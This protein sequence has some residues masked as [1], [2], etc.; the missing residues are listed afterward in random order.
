[1]Q[2]FL[3]NWAGRPPT[4]LQKLA[5][6][7]KLPFS[8]GNRFLT[9]PAFLD[10]E[11][12]GLVEADVGALLDL[13]FTLPRR[14]FDGDLA[15]MA[16]AVGL[17]PV[18]A[19]AIVRTATEYPVRLAR[20]DLFQD[21]GAFKLLEFK[22]SSA[23]GGWDAPLLT[24]WL[25]RD[26][27]LASF[28]GDE[29][30]TF[31]DTLA[32]FASVIRGECVGLDC[33]TRPVVALVDWPSSYPTYRRC[34]DFMVRSLGPLGFEA[35]GCHVGQLTARDGQ[36][37]L[38]GRHID[39]V[40]RFIQLGDLLDGP[41]ALAVM[42][43]IIDAAERGRV[44]L[45]TGFAAGVFASKDCLALLSDDDHHELFSL[46]ER[47]LI[48]RFLPWKRT[49]RAGE[50]FADGQQVDLAD[51]VLANRPELVLKPALLSAGLGVLLGWKT[52]QAAWAEAVRVGLRSRFVV[53]RRVRPVAERFPAGGTAAQPSELVLNWGCLRR[54]SG[55]RRSV[56]AG[57]S[58]I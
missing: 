55:L 37:F 35:T 10:A 1:M 54:G 50:T 27:D 34:L 58:G 29:G 7:L 49:L 51:Y 30:L 31:A 42:E 8:F 44:R 48:D 16:G 32:A 13:L 52:D 11:Q 56:R 45:V 36:L 19:E 22:I 47:D 12:R 6:E 21:G 2:R 4:R 5:Y 20:A 57:P 3:A 38:D 33:P 18:Q 46:A 28:V 15:A 17:A 43:P 9:R 39:V 24:R 41:D 40:H 53:Q 14:L 26:S 23:L 25:L